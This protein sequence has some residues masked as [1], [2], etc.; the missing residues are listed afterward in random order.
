MSD[1]IPPSSPTVGSP[2]PPAPVSDPAGAQVP[3]TSG[4]QSAQPTATSGGSPNPGTPATS[5]AD[6]AFAAFLQEPAATDNPPAPAPAPVATPPAPPAAEPPP[7]TPP[8]AEPSEAELETALSPTAEQQQQGL[9]PAK[10]LHRALASRRK[11][12]DQAKAMEQQLGQTNQLVDRMLD[13]LEHAGVSEQNLA[14]FM[15]NLARVRV[16]QQAKAAVLAQLGIEVPTAPPAPATPAIDIAAVEARL[17]VYDAE[18][19]LALI[20]AGLRPAAPAPATPPPATPPLA[21]PAAP[22]Q[23]VPT[24]ANQPQPPPAD[25]GM[26]QVRSMAT[27]MRSTIDLTFGKEDGQ[28][29]SKVID[30]AANQRLKELVD[31]GAQ[32]TPTTMA[33]VYQ[34]TY[35]KVLQ[36]EKQRLY[37]PPPSNPT[38]SQPTHQI[39]PAPVAPPRKLTADEQ[40]NAEFG[41]R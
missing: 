13:T 16:D 19:A 15:R 14:P 17:A 41:G 10:N 32:V 39:R 28:R 24:P 25:H 23:Q 26:Q 34:E 9:V 35:G 18:G 27:A 20:R 7:A 38:P 8:P 40:F 33:K 29:I 21:P 5:S 2:V 1:N 37:A 3:A 22:V 30:D 6:A 11:A 4:G 31:L 36:S 12:I